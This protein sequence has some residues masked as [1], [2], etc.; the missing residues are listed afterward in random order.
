M[1]LLKR[2]KPDPI[3]AIHPLPEY[4]AEGETKRRYE[5]M[6]S[7]LQVPWMGVVT[8]AYAHYPRFFDTLWDGWR[9]TC[10]S[11]PYIK[12]ARELRALAEDGADTLSPPP[13]AD[14][15]ETMGYAPR[16]FA[17]IREAIEVFSHGNNVYYPMCVAA[18]LL[19]EGGE[20]S[21]DRDKPEPF[22]GRHAPEVSVPFVMVER[23]HGLA[24]LQALYDDIMGT[25]KLPFVNSDYRMLA[26]WPSYFATAWSDLK[27]V[28]GTDAHEA[29]CQAFHDRA[30]ELAQTLPNPKGLTSADL[31]AAAEADAS[32]EEVLA[33][34]K[35]FIWLIPGLAVNVAFFRAQLAEDS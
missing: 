9:E 31:K 3:P 25:L 34:S 32:A 10:A 19:L 2:E 35:L 1:Y 17:A 30:V 27:P 24:D 33:V 4:K 21:D 23:H 5:D 15:L 8:M 12:A 6:K 7:V 14:R 18:R 16:E 22:E 28:V 13:I 29:A 26:R 20:M 11:A